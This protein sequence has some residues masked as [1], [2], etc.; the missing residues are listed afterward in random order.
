[1]AYAHTWRGWLNLA[2]LAAAS[3]LA[4]FVVVPAG[5]RVFLQSV[6]AGMEGTRGS[7]RAR[8]VR[9]DE[10]SRSALA[11]LASLER[12]LFVRHPGF[13]P[14]WFSGVCTGARHGPF[15]P[16]FGQSMQNNPFELL[17]L[18][19]LPLSWL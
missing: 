4:L 9:L 6:L 2:Y 15:L 19:R 7:G 10:R 13:A 17:A 1:M 5:E 11:T 8:Q 3:A 16:L 12:K 18:D 14:K